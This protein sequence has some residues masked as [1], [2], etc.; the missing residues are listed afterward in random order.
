MRHFLTCSILLTASV[1]TQAAA[2]GLPTWFPVQGLFSVNPDQLTSEDF[3]TDEFK[4]ANASG[5]YDT[6][7]VKGHHWST[8]LYPPGPESSWSWDGEAAWEKLKPQLEKQGFKLVYLQHDQGSYVDG[9]FRK[10]SDP[11]AT[12]VEVTLTKEDAY[13]NSVK[14]IDMAPPARSLVLTPPSRTPEKFG[15]K[16]NFPYVTPLAGAHLV[17][18]SRDSI[19]MDVTTSADT[20]AHLVGSGTITK[21]YDGPVGLSNLDLVSTY[22]TAFRTAGW[23]IVSADP[24]TGAGYVKA[25]Y[26]RDGRDIWTQIYRESDLRWDIQVADVGGSLRSALDSSCKVAIYGVNFDF[27]KATL[28]PDASPV[29][30]QVLALFNADPKLEAEIGGHTDNVGTPDYNLKLSQSRADAVK[31]WLVSHGVATARLTTRGYGDTAPVVPNT[32][33]QNRARN[34]RVE[35]KKPACR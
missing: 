30:Q 35:L 6:V 23:T 15:D 18:T 11:Q 34:R 19:P 28:R 24:A 27:D 29:L 20:E 10:G 22:Q 2:G 4:V 16:D 13:S 7:D 21:M 1:A 5:E 12:Y 33:D 25:H 26:N 14:I 3:G 32:S 31:A 8:S 17:T 9:T